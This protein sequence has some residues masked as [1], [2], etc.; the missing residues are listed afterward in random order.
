V[1]LSPPAG[2]AL[3]V[4]SA[5]P[6]STGA[7]SVLYSFAG[8]GEGDGETPDATLVDV[9]G[10]LYGT[11]ILGG[12][13]DHGT[14][15]SIASSG[16][17]TVLHSFSGLADGAYP[18]AGL[19]DVNGTFYGTT[20]E[21]GRWYHG[22]VFSIV[23]SGMEKVP[24]IFRSAD[25]MYPVASLIDVKGTLYGTTY[26]GGANNDGTVFSVTPSGKEK[27]LGTVPGAYPVAG[28]VDVKGRLYGTTTSGGAYC[29]QS[30]GC[31][32]VFSITPAGKEKLLHSFGSGTDGAY[33]YS[34][35][36]LNV[37]G[38]LYGTTAS[39][40]ANCTAH[41]GCGTVFAITASGKESVLHSFGG[42]GDGAY[43]DA[44]VINVKDTLYGTTSGGGAHNDGT[45]FSLKLRNA[46]ALA[47]SRPSHFAFNRHQLREPEALRMYAFY[48]ARVFALGEIAGNR[49]AH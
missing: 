4:T 46:I 36:L 23:P 40:G 20:M 12:T 18:E 31:G 15:F 49:R 3:G 13:D 42:L 1:P 45:V 8:S 22:T 29:N 35:F 32:T 39:G 37:K 26:E 14:V 28:F 25:G 2:P 27:M 19:L 11:T 47:G 21:G 43:P 30:N 44:G 5:Q 17:E 33:P 41:G 9:K 24:H 6:A 10:T 7:Y 34:G 38:T 16:T 48:R